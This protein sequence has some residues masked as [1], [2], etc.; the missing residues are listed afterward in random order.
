MSK[1]KKY[2]ENIK[3]IDKNKYYK[4]QE[5]LDSLKN[6]KTCKFDETVE[7]SLNL[8]IDPKQTDQMVRGTL[9]LPHGT[10]KKIRILAIAKGEAAKQAQEAGADIIGAEEIIKKIQDGWL[11]F[12]AVVTTPD[13]MRDISKLG[14]VLGPRGL[15]PNPKAG[16][17]S[18]ELGPLIKDIKAGMIEFKVD[19]GANLHLI[20]GKLSF[21]KEK[22]KENFSAALETIKKAKPASC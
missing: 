20:I 15:M 3:Q 8:G 16:T 7:L 5:A 21:D 19:Q 9:K 22:I 4:I 6:F 2:K 1:G 11:D 10:G 17:V 12:D 13:M 18:K 14:R